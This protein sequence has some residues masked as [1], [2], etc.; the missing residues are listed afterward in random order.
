[1]L[2]NVAWILDFGRKGSERNK[3]QS[4]QNLTVYIRNV[5]KGTDKTKTQSSENRG[6][7]KDRLLVV[8]S[9]QE[10]IEPAI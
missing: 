3:H 8:F 10:P 7:D 6:T 5:C 1:M 2:H 4:Q 9:K